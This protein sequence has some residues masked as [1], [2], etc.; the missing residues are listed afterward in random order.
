MN[1]A[2]PKVFGIGFHKTGTSSLG[3]ALAMMG[4]RVTGP[5]FVRHPEV[6]RFGAAWAQ[7]IIPR[8]DAF[9][10]NPWPLLF[11]EVDQA[12]PGS[13]FI[14]T[15]RDETAWL[16]S[17]VRYFGT[18]DTPMRRWIYGEDAGS[19]VNNEAV[20]LER[21]RQHIRE[22]RAYFRGRPDDLLEFDIIAGQGWGRLGAFLGRAT[23]AQ[24]P[25]PH[26]NRAA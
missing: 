5:N 15:L 12:W 11:R 25:F 2:Q 9:Q 18:G 8:Y 16:N 3:R 4:Y 19:P 24:R 13:R 6:Q 14:L 21:Y 17:A 7:E 1:Q 20:Y 22:V 10:D 26:E 23:P